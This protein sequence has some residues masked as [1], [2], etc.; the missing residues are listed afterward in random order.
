LL[1]KVCGTLDHC[2][3]MPYSIHKKGD[4]LQIY[5]CVIFDETRQHAQAHITS[6]SLCALSLAAS[7]T[8]MESQLGW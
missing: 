1:Q 5:F 6:G 3:V 4:I 2:F 8:Q 7:R